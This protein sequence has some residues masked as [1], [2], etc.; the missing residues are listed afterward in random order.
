MKT[1]KKVGLF[2]LAAACVMTLASCSEAIAKPINNKDPILSGNDLSLV[3]NVESLVYKQLHDSST[4]GSDVTNLLFTKIF[5]ERFG[6]YDEIC[7]NV[8]KPDAELNAFVDDHKEYQE[9]DNS[10]NRVTTEFAK[11]QERARVVRTYNELQRLIAKNLWTNINSSSY[12][13]DDMYNERLFALYVY[14]NLY[15]LSSTQNFESLEFYGDT[16]DPVEA[17]RGGILFTPD[18]EIFDQEKYEWKAEGILHLEYYQDYIKRYIVPTAI[19]TI[20]SEKYIYTNQYSSLGRKYGR[21]VE[22]IAIPENTKF[23]GYAKLLCKAFINN[24]TDSNAD[25]DEFEI[26]ANAWRG[27]DIVSGSEEDKLLTAAGFAKHDV[28]ADQVEAL[29]TTAEKTAFGSKTYYDGTAFGDQLIDFLKIK[30]DVKTTDTSIESTYSNSGKYS[31]YHG[32][33]LK[34][35]TVKQTDYVTEDWGVKASGFTSLP[36][37]I[38]SRLFN[39]NTSLDLQDPTDSD[40]LRKVGDYTYLM[41]KTYEKQDTTPFLLYD[42]STY[43]LVRVKEAA[44]NSKLSKTKVEGS[45]LDIYGDELGKLYCETV[46]YKI[47][48][49]VADDSTTKNSAL[50]YIL[51]NATIDYNDQ[52]IYDYFVSTYP[53]LFD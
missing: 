18:V 46:A 26:L 33:E 42:S 2:A 47:A 23:P 31:Y 21:H 20:L 13:V 50:L 38:K 28:T 34:T 7:E 17:R 32:F 14:K 29:Y 51:E 41:P 10:G 35:K 25:N 37:E 52:S 15:T 11:K 36:D 6:S 3:N 48:S 8:T 5:N 53:D 40:Y 4:Y 44:S 9:F 43:Y 22:Y 49:L 19:Q 1:N 24:L 39:I 16:S 27:V 45:Y 12:K 30:T